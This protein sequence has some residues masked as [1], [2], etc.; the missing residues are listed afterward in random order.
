MKAHKRMGCDIVP[1]DFSEDL[2]HHINAI[3]GI[4]SH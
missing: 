3:V 1:G 2:G 4:K